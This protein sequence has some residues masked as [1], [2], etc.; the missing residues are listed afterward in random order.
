MA[1]L[2]VSAGLHSSLGAPGANSFSYIFQL[3][4]IPTSRVPLFS[5]IHDT[6]LSLL[7][8]QHQQNVSFSFCH[9]VSSSFQVPLQLL[10]TLVIALEPPA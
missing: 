9:L 3:L 8:Q 4:E 7:S 10:R 2:K 6:F 5:L 1:K